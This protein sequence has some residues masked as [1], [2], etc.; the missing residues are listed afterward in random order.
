MRTWSI[1][2]LGGLRP[3]VK[4][5][6]MGGMTSCE[7]WVDSQA[8]ASL[9]CLL[10]I[11]AYFCSPCSFTPLISVLNKFCL[12]VFSK[13]IQTLPWLPTGLHANW[14]WETNFKQ[15]NSGDNMLSTKCSFWVLNNFYCSN[16]RIFIYFFQI[17]FSISDFSGLYLILRS[18][19]YH[20]ISHCFIPTRP[21][22]AV[23]G[24]S[25]KVEIISCYFPSLYKDIDFQIQFYAGMLFRECSDTTTIH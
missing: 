16:I 4:W 2:A 21:P 5:M 14:I 15:C 3:R 20:D 22:E 11:S 7:Y 12:S 8:L 25:S 1:R 24:I 17:K 18:T 23:K 10:S 9:L 19:V 6:R 13:S